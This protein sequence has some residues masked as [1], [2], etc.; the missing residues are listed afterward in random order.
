M[1]VR[2]VSSIVVFMYLMLNIRR[3]NKQNNLNGEEKPIEYTN[4]KLRSK[5][6]VDK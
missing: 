1:R 5:A 3:E 4:S 6:K 2:V